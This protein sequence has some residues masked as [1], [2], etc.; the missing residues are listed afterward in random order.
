MR[1]IR[2]PQPSW[3]SSGGSRTCWRDDPNRAVKAGSFREGTTPGFAAVK[4]DLPC[5]SSMPIKLACGLIL[6]ALARLEPPADPPP[7]PAPER[8]A[9]LT[10]TA[11]A[12]EIQVGDPLV[13]KVALH[14]QSAKVVEL[15]GPF[16]NW[17]RLV[18]FWVRRGNG[19][20]FV[21]TGIQTAG[22]LSV[23]GGTRRRVEPGESAVTRELLFGRHNALVFAEAGEWQLRATARSTEAAFTSDPITIRVKPRAEKEGAIIRENLG[24]M[25]AAL[26]TFGGAG[27]YAGDLLGRLGPQLSDS[28]L[29]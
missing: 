29:K 26:F 3:G 17:T 12:A 20:E 16:T 19:G 14:N 10:V 9:H 8:A 13:V 7:A 21:Q 1:T 5:E 27:R 11:E 24:T 28:H 23:G 6:A 2:W 22:R 4:M 15:P 18:K 25:A